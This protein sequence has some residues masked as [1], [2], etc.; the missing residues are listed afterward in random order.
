LDKPKANTI[1]GIQALQKMGI[2]TVMI[3]GDTK[4][5]VAAIALQ[6]GIDKQYGEIYPEQKAAIIKELQV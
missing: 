6:I 4:K 1:K 5:T 2:K 3:S